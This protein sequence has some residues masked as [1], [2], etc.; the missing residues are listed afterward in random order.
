MKRYQFNKET[1]GLYN[2]IRKV[3]KLNIARVGWH[4]KSWKLIEDNKTF[5]EVAD[6]N[7][8][9]LIEFYLRDELYD[10]LLANNLL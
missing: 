8:K 10:Y 6:K 9:P 2:N 4:E 7:Y 1:Y 5:E 3:G